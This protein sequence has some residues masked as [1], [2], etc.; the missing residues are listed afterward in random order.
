MMYIVFIQT[1]KEGSS[2]YDRFQI[3]TFFYTFLQN[4]DENQH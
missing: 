4:T 2:F 1:S 3:K